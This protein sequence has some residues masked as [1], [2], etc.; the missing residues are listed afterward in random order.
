[1]EASGDGSRETRSLVLYK[2][3]PNTACHITS[4][5]PANLAQAVMEGY[6][7][8]LEAP[9]ELKSIIVGLTDIGVTH[10]F[11]LKLPSTRKSTTILRHLE[12]IWYQ[13][14]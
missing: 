2:L 5:D 7:T 9:Q 1:M 11:K 10:Y 13:K 14:K 6:Y 12:L 4:V 3:K 8:L